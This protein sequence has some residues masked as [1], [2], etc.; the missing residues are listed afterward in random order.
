MDEKKYWCEL[1]YDS[2]RSMNI[3]TMKLVL[4]YSS[5]Q[6]F[7]YTIDSKRYCIAY[8]AN[9]SDIT[10]VKDPSGYEIVSGFVKTNISLTVNG[11]LVD[12]TVQTFYR[13]VGVTNYKLTY[14][15]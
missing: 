6:S 10:S 14:I 8:P 7:T 4:S 15:F 2:S 1:N 13:L 9:W 5:D 3:K 12:Y 11:S